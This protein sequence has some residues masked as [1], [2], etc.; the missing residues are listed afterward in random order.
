MSEL[1]H[2]TTGCTPGKTISVHGVNPL[3]FAVALYDFHVAK[4]ANMPHQV[5][6]HWEDTC[7][8]PV[9]T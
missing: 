8:G 7:G 2:L 3:I 4:S 1:P 9:R 6:M 5:R